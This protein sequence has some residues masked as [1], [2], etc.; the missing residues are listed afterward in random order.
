LFNGLSPTNAANTNGWPIMPVCSLTDPNGAAGTWSI[1][2]DDSTNVTM[3]GPGGLSTN[4]VFDPA[5]AALFADPVTICVGGQPNNTVGG[6]TLIYSSFSATGCVSTINDTFSADTGLDAT[7]W[8]NISND[9]NG[10]VLA[11]VG[12]IYWLDWSLPDAGF[13][14]QTTASLAGTPN[15][16]SLAS[17]GTIQDLG[18]RAVLLNVANLPS[19]NTGYFQLVQHVFTQL[20][21]LLPGET[22]APGTPTGKTGTPTPVSLGAGGLI[23]FTVNAVD[24]NW[25]PVTG[26]T[27]T[28]AITSSDGSATLPLNGALVN[29]TATFTVQ[30]ATTADQTITATDV[31]T[32]TILPNT[33]SQVSVTP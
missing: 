30:F 2:F 11:P 32:A 28:I 23:T 8:K 31:T 4:F 24:P 22:A 21:V 19:A 1:T 13:S 7:T 3:T 12:S 29:G 14:L 17:V 20:Q 26:I 6:Q 16:T 9:T 33:S 25:N 27:D 10:C 5:S 15:W 18:Q